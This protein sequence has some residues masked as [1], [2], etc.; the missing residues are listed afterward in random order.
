MDDI[1]HN[2][3]HYPP[4]Q[5]FMIQ[6]RWQIKHCPCK[7]W[8]VHG[9]TKNTYKNNTSVTRTE[10]LTAIKTFLKNQQQNLIFHFCSS[11]KQMNTRHLCFNVST[12]AIPSIWF[13]SSSFGKQTK[14]PIIYWDILKLFI[15]L[16]TSYRA[17]TWQQ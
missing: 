11:G 8:H 10:I 9:A 3:K 5:P 15:T 6:T 16:Q 1:P 17:M 14:Q 12:D 13:F 7:I 4:K 2:F